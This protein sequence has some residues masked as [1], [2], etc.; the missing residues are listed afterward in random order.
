M[1]AAVVG[2]SGL[3]I[4]DIAQ[5]VPKPNE[6]L[7]R[8]RAC[9]LN[10]ADAM[11]ASGAAHGRAGGA[12]TVVGLEY[13]G[14][15][16]AVGAEVRHVKPG[17]RV[18][19][20]GMGGWAEYAVADWGRALP[21]PAN[22]MSWTQAATLPVALATMHNALRGAGRL[23][24]GEAVLIQGA[25]SGVGLMG[26]Q[27]AKAMGARLVIGS[28]TNA[29]R[30]ER[31]REFGADLAIDSRA[32]DWVEQVLEATGGEGVD[33]IVDMLSGYVANQ[34]LAA[35]RVLGRI[36]NV[37]RLGGGKGEFNFDLHALRRIEYIGVTFRTRSLEEVRELVQSM[38]ADLWDKVEA[39]E[40]SL[41]I[42]REFALDDASAAVEYMKANRHFGKIV[43][44]V[45]A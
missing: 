43:L 17:D 2:E 34:N 21:I 38:R 27:I 32:A 14:E 26:Q 16:A 10:R 42:D 22:N 24:A 15:V 33:L 11:V 7:V 9:G 37:G 45:D 29:Q 23:R 28:S 41:P 36:V 19:C 30:R 44:N 39:G 35:T 1:K 12:G 20:S 3:E 25:S 18:M 5:P 40:L 4:R 8:V 13:A 31:L 6:V